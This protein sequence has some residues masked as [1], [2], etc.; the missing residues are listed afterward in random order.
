MAL[1]RR[2]AEAARGAN[3]VAGFLARDATMAVEVDRLGYDFVG[4]SGDVNIMVA[5]AK[6]ALDDARAGL[7]R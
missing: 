6:R 4:I 2:V 3:K 7:R 5:A 1:V